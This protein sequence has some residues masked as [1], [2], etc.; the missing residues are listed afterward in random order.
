[1]PFLLVPGTLKISVRYTEATPSLDL[2]R[3]AAEGQGAVGRP[4][5]RHLPGLRFS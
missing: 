4:V 2:E 1:M 3:A 5:V